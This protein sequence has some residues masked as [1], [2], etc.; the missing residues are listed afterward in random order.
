MIALDAAAVASLRR[1]LKARLLGASPDTLV[2][3]D[4]ELPPGRE[5]W[6]ER[7]PSASYRYWAV[8]AERDYRLG[9]GRALTLTAAGPE[10]F[11]TLKRAFGGLSAA[12]HREP[13][14][15][16]SAFLGF[17]FDSA[18]GSGMPCAEIT[19]P[20]VL[21]LCRAGKRRAIF[22]C[23]ARD[24]CAA[25]D[26]WLSALARRPLRSGSR[27]WH[28]RVTPFADRMWL[29]R[30]E[31]ALRDITA[32]RLEKV[33]LGRNA[34]LAAKE[35]FSPLAILSALSRRHEGSTVFAVGNGESSFLGLTPE[36]LVISGCPR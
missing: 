3:V 7:E 8:P 36:R 6:L 28:R 32:G 22:S 21:L 34:H 13:E 2:S 4:L 25:P 24:A 12:W 17:S 26:A 35:D 23:L 33:V 5:D 30:V 29:A 1:E 10:R 31:T 27:Q 18:S 19:V 15:A 14:S 20:S 16:A 9:L 11:A